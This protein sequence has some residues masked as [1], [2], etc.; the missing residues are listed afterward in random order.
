MPGVRRSP[1]PG[2]GR[3]RRDGLEGLGRTDTLGLAVVLV[4]V[5]LVAAVLVGVLLVA[6]VLGGASVVVGL[7]IETRDLIVG[8]TDT[9]G[10]AVVSS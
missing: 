3:G 4:G 10:W 7:T 9:F 5:V 8:L 2:R 1:K 6:G